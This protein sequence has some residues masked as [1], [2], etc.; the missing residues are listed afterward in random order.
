MEITRTTTLKI[1][2]DLPTA[3]ATVQA[4]TAACNY[5]SAVAFEHDCLSNTVALHRLCYLNVRAQFGLSAQVTASAIRQVAAKY[6]AAKTSK[7]ILKRPVFFRENAVALQGG[8]RGRDVSFTQSGLSVWTLN[9][10]MKAIAFRGEPKV[11]EY[12]S[13]WQLGDA[14]LYVRNGKV[15]LSVSFKRE[16]PDR[17]LPNDAVI[18]VDRG[19]NYLAVVTDGKRQR[20]F[21]GGRV[22]HVRNH[23]L[24]TRASLQR[25]KA[26]KP[27]RSIRRRLKRLS[28]REARF[29]RDVNHTTSRRIVEFALAT[30]NPTIAI[31][32]LEGIRD[33]SKKM[34]KT[35]RRDINSWAFYQLGEFLR[36]KSDAYGFVII[37][38]DPRNTSRGC[39]RCGYV[40][41][42]NRNRHDFTCKAC[43]Y[44][45]HADLNA[46]RN[47]R[48]RGLLARQELSEDGVLSDT[49]QA[50]LSASVANTGKLPD[51]SGSI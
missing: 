1:A 28:G 24:K 10:R 30:G 2:L 23:F 6:V 36:Y 42:S 25:K 27:T 15:Y 40:D 49:P 38:I 50:R 44:S 20:F 35:Q 37:E 48:L 5:L 39:S 18:G 19:I 12:L 4:W 21:G 31:E 8:E 26:Q 22:K 33:R 11:A 41:K 46:S 45:L 16:I 47:I 14:R 51:S 3:T 29:M 9:G 13:E 32:A 7:H 17:E 43:G 34:R